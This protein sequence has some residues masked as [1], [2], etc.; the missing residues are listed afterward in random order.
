MITPERK[1]SA[2]CLPVLNAMSP[3]LT[4]EELRRSVRERLADGRL[5]WASGVSTL[6]RGTGRPCNVCGKTLEKET[7]EREVQGP[8]EGYALTHEDCFRIWREESRRVQPP[9]PPA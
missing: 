4:D 7:T 2:Q 5:F 6:R 8:R 1:D 3:D 9:P